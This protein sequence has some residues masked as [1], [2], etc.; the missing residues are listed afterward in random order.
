MFTKEGTTFVLTKATVA[1]PKITCLIGASYGAGNY[2]MCDRDYAP[3]F[4]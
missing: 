3:M 2:G 4:L 1:V